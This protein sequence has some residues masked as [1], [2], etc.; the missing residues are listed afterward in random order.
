MPL[1]RGADAGGMIL[2]SLEE[3]RPG[4]VLGVGLRNSK[5][6]TLLGPGQVLNA[7]Y[8]GRLQQLGYCAVW[9]DDEDTRDIPYEDTLSEATRIATMGAVQDTFAMTLRETEQLRS[10]SL[11]EVKGT[12]E[13]RR[14]HQAFQD[15]PIIE[16]LTDNIDA[17]V[18]EVLDRAVLT[19]LGSLR[20][21][22]AYIYHHSLDAAVTATMIGR[23]L[24]YD[25]KTLNQLAVG[26]I[27]HDI[28]SIFIG[29]DI[30][31]KPERLSEEEFRRM[32]DH[33]SLGYLFIRD[34]LKVGLIAAHIAYQHHERQDGAGY[35]RALTGANRVVTGAEMHLPGRITPLAEIAAI[36]DFH[37]AC[38][39]ERP[40]RPRMAAD[41]VWQTLRDAAGTHLNREM[42]E[43][44]LN[45]LPPYPLGTMVEVTSGTWRDHRAVVAK[46]HREALHRPVIRVLEGPSGARVNAVDID[47]R[48]DEATI[49]GLAG[50]MV[51]A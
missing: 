43:M 23:L 30:L 33:T 5:G 19:G 36:A 8:I 28:G 14:F 10:L 16:R 44:F 12:L 24:R 13:D 31:D 11:G 46:V 2:L 40:H 20:T 7:T 42:V 47:L 4:M 38:S 41:V 32:K 1:A 51:A 25:K 35:P 22:S 45:V 9:I 50:R 21:H 49:R 15:S 17:M 18:R 48:K 27:L 29:S 3:V 37:D 6:H 26:C 34:S 39:S